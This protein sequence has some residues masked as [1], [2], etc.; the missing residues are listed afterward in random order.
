MANEE[1]PEADKASWTIKSVPVDV[2]KLAVACAAK[3]DQTMAEWL[4]RAV[5]NQANL[6][7]GERILPP[8][9][10]AASLPAVLPLGAAV[11]DAPDIGELADLMQAAQALA[12]AADVPM[13][14]AMARHA[15]ALVTAQLRAARGLPAKQPRRTR[16]ENGQTIEAEAKFTRGQT[17]L[18]N[19]QTEEAETADGG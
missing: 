17:Y 11:V 7:A 2:R 19:R 13:P 16:H 14:K 18:E 8:A 15:L 6:E 9:S 12:A 5:R 3:Q 10:R 1:N 4:E